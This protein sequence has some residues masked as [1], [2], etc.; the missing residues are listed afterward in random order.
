MSMQYR[1]SLDG[2]SKLIT[3]GILL[4]MAFLTY[5]DFF[6]SRPPLLLSILLT[7]LFLGIIVGGYLY[8]PTGYIL[9][10]RM[11]IIARPINKVSIALASIT[12]ARILMKGETGTL[13][14]IKGS[15]G[16]FGY[17][18]NFRSTRMGKLK[19]FATRRNNRILITTNDDERLIITPDDLSI[20]QMIS[21]SMYS[22]QS[23]DQKSNAGKRSQ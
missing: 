14:R 4:M 12:G 18:G 21:D 11:L 7:V 15:G 20:I 6:I 1:A 19:L 17:Y 10:N 3:G 9:E 2:A 13:I 23:H 22:E 5:I 16:F 8:S